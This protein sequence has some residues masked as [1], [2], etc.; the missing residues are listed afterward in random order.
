M[1]HPAA[2]LRPFAA[3]HR[4]WRLVYDRACAMPAVW[5]GMMWVALSGLV[6][7]V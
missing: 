1:T 3:I 6:F 5:R 7:S 2:A 4:V